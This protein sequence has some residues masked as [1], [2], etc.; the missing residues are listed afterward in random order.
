M[1]SAQRSSSVAWPKLPAPGF[2]HHSGPALPPS[3]AFPALGTLQVHRSASG[4]RFFEHTTR[5]TYFE[6]SGTPVTVVAP[7]HLVSRSGQP[8]S[9]KHG[10]PPRTEVGDPM[11]TAQLA[12]MEIKYKKLLEVVCACC[13]SYWKELHL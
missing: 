8:H 2:A 12:M 13:R 11:I 5:G 1:S 9:P 4:L 6:V 7:A 3:P 10:T